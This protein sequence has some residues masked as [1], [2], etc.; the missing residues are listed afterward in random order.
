M[1]A[2]PISIIAQV[3]GSG[4]VTAIIEE[5]VAASVAVMTYYS[6]TEKGSVRGIRLRCLLWPD[7][8]NV[9]EPRD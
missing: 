5:S 6:V 4:T 7:P 9:S 3:E 1:P 2:K 8:V